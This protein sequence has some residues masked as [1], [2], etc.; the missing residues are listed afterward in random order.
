MKLYRNDKKDNTKIRRDNQRK[1]IKKIKMIKKN[2][3]W[4]NDK[5]IKQIKNK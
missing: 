3:T 5:K 2:E 4:K 1:K